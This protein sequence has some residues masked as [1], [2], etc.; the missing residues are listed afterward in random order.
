MSDQFI[1]MELKGIAKNI[2]DKFGIKFAYSPSGTA[3]FNGCRLVA[4]VA[5]GSKTVEQ[6]FDIR[7]FGDAA[8]TLAAVT[9][10]DEIH[11]YADY[12]MQKGR[13]E[14]WYPIATITEVISIG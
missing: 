2:S 1:K 6:R 14:K 9:E 12:G 8:E 11:V 5:V 7:A 3:Y 13:D 4:N 10:G